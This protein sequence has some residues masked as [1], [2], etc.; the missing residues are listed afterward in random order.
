MMVIVTIVYSNTI[1]K[2]TIYCKLYDII[3]SMLIIGYNTIISM[4]FLG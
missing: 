3:M 1:K 4:T 2:M